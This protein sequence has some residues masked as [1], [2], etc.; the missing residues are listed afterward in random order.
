MDIQKLR[1]F[2]AV[3]AT[4]SIR[5][6]AASLGYTP[7]AISQQ[8][9]ALQRDFGLTLFQ[10]SGRGIEM[11]AAGRTLAAQSDHVFEQIAQLESLITDLRVGR[12][13]ALSIGYFASAGATWLPSVVVALKQEFP[14]LRLDLRLIDFPR[15]PA[16]PASLDLEV[17]VE[18][19]EVTPQDGFST[20]RLVTEPYL[21][22]VSTAS[23]L[24]AKARVELA[25]LHTEA[26]ID[27]DASGG[28]CRQ[29]MLDACSSVGFAP[30][31][32]I[33][34]HDY[35]TAIRFVAEGMG[36]T[37]VPRLGVGLLPAGTVAVPV[38]NPTPHRTIVIRV[39]DSVAGHPAVIRA[40]ALLAARAQGQALAA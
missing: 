14:T 5:G 33:E 9:A 35:P 40:V 36:I 7:S 2:R 13:G 15:T 25:D 3:A 26:W 20:R 28:P 16:M 21:V 11:T 19:A 32:Q 30:S 10:K 23:P 24:A 12:T 17:A 38:V 27:N 1:V 4:G 29:R 8:V 18:G 6:A 39:R 37:V 31:F 34:A 22:V